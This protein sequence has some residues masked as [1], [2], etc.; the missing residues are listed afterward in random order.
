MAYLEV[1]KVLRIAVTIPVTTASN[2]RLFSGLEIV[3]NYL[4]STTGDESSQSPLFDIYREGFTKKK[5]ISKKVGYDQVVDDFAKM[6]PQ[7]FPLLP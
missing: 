1:I 7:R 6:I 5:F 2:K 3:K 4:R